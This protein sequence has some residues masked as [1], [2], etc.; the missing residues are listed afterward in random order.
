[1]K[2]K[3]IIIFGPLSSVPKIRNALGPLAVNC[4]SEVRNLGVFL[5]S[6]LNFNKQVSSVVKGSFFQLRRIAKLKPWLSYTDV[7]TVIH[8]FVTSRLDYCN[9]L[10]L[11]LN[12]S[13]LARLQLVQNATARLLTGTKKHMHI[14]PV[15][16][17][18]HWLP[19]NYRIHFKVLLFVFKA[20][21]GMAPQSI[22]DLLS[23][24]CHSRPLRSSSQ[25]L[26]VPKATLKTKGDRAF[27]V[28]APRLWNN[29]PIEIK[30]SPTISSFKSN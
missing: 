15:L 27:S 21:N 6:S 25:L 19:V 22:F 30:S 11:G 23:P 28:A 26:S 18:L 7:E 14:S 13:T 5:D 29:L 16:A 4:H 2:R 9:S 8:A 1:M 3:E 12:Q 17:Q 20:L 24:Y 10:Y